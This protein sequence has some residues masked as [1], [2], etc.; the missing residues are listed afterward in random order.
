MRHSSKLS[1]LLIFV[2]TADFARTTHRRYAGWRIL[3]ISPWQSPSQ[4][5]PRT[6][7]GNNS[8][9]HCKSNHPR[10]NGEQKDCYHLANN[11]EHVDPQGHEK[12]QK[13]EEKN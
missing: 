8:Y 5:E 10:E 4:Y 7:A 13:H 6:A 1:L 9:E 2:S 11:P 3:A 12:R